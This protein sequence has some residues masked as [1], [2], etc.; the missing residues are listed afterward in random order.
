MTLKRSTT[1][2]R[3]LG[4][5]A[6]SSA[7]A[8]GLGSCGLGLHGTEVS[9][10]SRNPLAWLAGFV[11]SG[12]I[13]LIG[14]GRRLPIGVVVVTVVGLAA[15]LLAKDQFGVHRW[16][17]VG[18]L[19]FNVAALL[20]PVALVALSTSNFAPAV[21]LA[22]SGAIGVILVAQP[23][24]SQATAFLLASALILIR[25]TQSATFLTCALLGMA[26]LAM[27]AW[28]RPDPLQPVPE[29]EGIFLLLADISVALAAAAGLALA[30]TCLVPLR[31]LSS[32]SESRRSAATTLSVYF[33]A[34]ALMPFL[35]AYPVPLVGM[36]MSFPVGFWLAMA[37]MS[38]RE[39]PTS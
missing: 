17:D 31:N 29:V 7:V 35:G 4:L 27:A 39:H 18:P 34:A 26:S 16:L 15:S 38:A 32:M 36:G 30:L 13:V 24:A 6:A 1:D 10:W 8:V 3:T 12:A 23:D 37:L 11:L 20:L 19:H 33:S 28:L 25:R 2:W 9:T 22:I 5:F 21:L 14:R